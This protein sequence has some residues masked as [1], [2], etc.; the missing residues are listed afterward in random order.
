[1]SVA[2]VAVVRHLRAHPHGENVWRRAVAPQAA[3]DPLIAMLILTMAVLGV[4][5]GHGGPAQDLGRSRHIPY[6]WCTRRC[7]G[8]R[9]TPA[10]AGGL[11]GDRARQPPP[12]ARGPRHMGSERAA[13]R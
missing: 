13:T 5:L 2:A 3:R 6:G 11:R 1:M 10:P 12:P 8:K 9:P 7:V 4:L